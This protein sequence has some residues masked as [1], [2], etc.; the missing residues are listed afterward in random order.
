MAEK[1]CLCT[2]REPNAVSDSRCTGVTAHKVQPCAADARFASSVQR[3]LGD[4]ETGDDPLC[5]E[6]LKQI[7]FP[8]FCSECP[9]A[10]NSINQGCRVATALLIGR[11]YACAMLCCVGATMQGITGDGLV[12]LETKGPLTA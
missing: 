9:C 5:V 7:R 3:S 1:N 12:F 8:C 11:Y 2:A 10:A 4:A 6:Q